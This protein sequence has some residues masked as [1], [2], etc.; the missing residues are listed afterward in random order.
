MKIH[1]IGTSI[2]NWVSETKNRASQ[3]L[4]T[5]AGKRVLLISKIA[6]IAISFVGAIAAAI[7]LMPVVGPTFSFLIAN[8]IFIPALS[9]IK[10]FFPKPIGPTLAQ[11]LIVDSKPAASS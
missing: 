3:F 8:V 11:N 2:S 5:D 9:I 4:E 1:A 6:F 10:T 7:L